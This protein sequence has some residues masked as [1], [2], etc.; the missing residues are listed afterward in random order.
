MIIRYII[1]ITLSIL[2][3]GC[4]DK[5]TYPLSIEKEKMVSILMDIT[6]AEQTIAKFDVSVRDS[7]FELFRN[8]MAEIYNV[9]NFD[10]Q[11]NM[12]ELQQNPELFREINDLS[13]KKMQER[14]KALEEKKND[15]S[16][17][18]EMKST[19]K[20]DKEVPKNRKNN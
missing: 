7:I 8:Q 9:S 15:V 4:S 14:S 17:K 18:K 1:I 10:I 11:K 6:I 12:L 19:D 20:D 3:S 2:L 13:T 5:E 16:K